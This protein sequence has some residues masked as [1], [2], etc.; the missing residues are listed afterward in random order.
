MEDYINNMMIHDD[1]INSDEDEENI[2][3]DPPIVNNEIV[4]E[5]S[6]NEMAAS[7]NSLYGQVMLF[8]FN[9][10]K[11]F[12]QYFTNKKGKFSTGLFANK[13]YT[14][15]VINVLHEN[16]IQSR[17]DFS[18]LEKDDFKIYLKT[19]ANTLDEMVVSANRIP[20]KKRDVIQKIRVMKSEE[21]Q[22]QNQSSMADLVGASGN[23]FVQKSQLGGGSPIIRGF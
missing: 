4:Q 11:D 8:D 13:R 19:N 7:T 3:N 14:G 21:I 20:E 10:N 5:L 18:L 9:Y 23:V 22:N 12:E 2:I 16:Y 1:V 17:Y 6:M 15:H